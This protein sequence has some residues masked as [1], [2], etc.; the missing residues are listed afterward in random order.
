MY[1]LTLEIGSNKQLLD[2]IGNSPDYFL[3]HKH[4]PQPALRWEKADIH[5]NGLVLDN[6][7]IRCLQFDVK[8]NFQELNRIIRHSIYNISIYQFEKPIA[9]TLV[10]EYLPENAKEHI[11]RK[12]GLKHIFSLEYEFLTVSSFDESFIDNIRMHH[13][14]SKSIIEKK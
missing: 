6:V 14:Y 9:D 2:I 10:I 3:L 1:N 4:M 12:N 7:D 13:V 5:I 8:T 11:L